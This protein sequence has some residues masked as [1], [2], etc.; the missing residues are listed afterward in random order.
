MKLDVKHPHQYGDHA[1]ALG[2]VEGID[3]LANH[4]QPGTRLRQDR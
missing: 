1:M 4:P 2:M 3:G